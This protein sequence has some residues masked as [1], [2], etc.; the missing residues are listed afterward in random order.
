M[1]SYVLAPSGRTAYL[2]ELRSGS[3][4]VVVDA[5]TGRRRTALVGRVKIE[6][7]PLVSGRGTGWGVLGGAGRAAGALIRRR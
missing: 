7:R 1:H 5:A 3:E 6:T 2:S 4:V